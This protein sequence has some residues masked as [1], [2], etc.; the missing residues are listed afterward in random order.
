MIGDFFLFFLLQ[1]THRPN[2][3]MGVFKSR[4]KLSYSIAC[5][6]HIRAGRMPEGPLLGP[7]AQ[8]CTLDYLCNNHKGCLGRAT[9]V[10]AAF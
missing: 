7:L 1:L 5:I 3:T 2:R 4:I 10:V 6:L 8:A 9:T